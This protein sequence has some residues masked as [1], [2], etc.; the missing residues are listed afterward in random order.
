MA[1]LPTLRR[2]HFEILALLAEAT[3]TPAI[4]ER[5]KGALNTIRGC[6]VDLRKHGYVVALGVSGLTNSWVRTNAGAQAL[7]EWLHANP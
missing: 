6:L 7:Q 5:L 2:R 4:A 3:P 1:T